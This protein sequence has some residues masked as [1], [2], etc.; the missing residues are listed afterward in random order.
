MSDQQLS[1]VSVVVPVGPAET[2]LAP[3]L[4]QLHS[5]AQA[6][7]IIFVFCPQSEHLK[8]QL[9]DVDTRIVAQTAPAG[10]AAQLNAGSGV[11]R[12]DYLWFLHLDSRF[13]GGQWQA[14]GRAISRY[15]QRLHYYDL[16]FESDGN[17]PMWLNSKGA[18]LR[19]RWLGLPFGDQGF[20]LSRKQFKKLGGYPS[21]APYG[22]DHLFIWRAHQQGVRLNNTD[23]VL[24]TS[25]RKY[26][27]KGWGELTLLYQWY[28][29]RQ[30]L[31]EFF[32]LLK[33]RFL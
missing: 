22:E 29:V 18:N 23:S 9:P 21:D 32:K 20:C 11:A 16:L 2:D 14:L 19:S 12:A 7:Q 13:G 33:M 5:L 15:P 24:T 17:G 26:A 6:Q 31:P 30:A 25:A 8:Q 4:S 3:F 1:S 28:W 10:R 27:V